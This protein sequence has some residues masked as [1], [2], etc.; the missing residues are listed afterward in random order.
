MRTTIEKLRTENEELRGRS[1]ERDNRITTLER[2]N[3]DLE[4]RNTELCA[5]FA[6][7]KERV[8]D[9]VETIAHLRGYIDRVREDDT[10]REELVTVGDLEGERSMVP[11]RRHAFLPVDRSPS[12]PDTDRGAGG[13]SYFRGVSERRKPRQWVNY[14][15]E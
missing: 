13:A 2:D 4:K 6:D 8:R 7:L 14:G 5:Q 12:L 3:R 11:K 10:V 9:Q 1:A 15:N